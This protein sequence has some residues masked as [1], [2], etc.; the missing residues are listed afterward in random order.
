MAEFIFATIKDS[1]SLYIFIRKQA[2]HTFNL[3]TCLSSIAKKAKIIDEG[4]NRGKF[5]T[6]GYRQT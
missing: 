2:L 6:P 3:I 5:N 1:I 4:S